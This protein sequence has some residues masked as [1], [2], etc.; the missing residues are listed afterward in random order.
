[1]PEIKIINAES[2]IIL[3][4][5]FIVDER[6]WPRLQ[7]KIQ[8]ERIAECLIDWSS[9]GEFI[10]VSDAMGH[11]SMLVSFSIMTSHNPFESKSLSNAELVDIARNV[12]SGPEGI[13]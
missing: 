6:S 2:Q 10:D 8:I 1:M 3:L 12:L 9:H 13:A 5:P 7:D 4:L 11:P